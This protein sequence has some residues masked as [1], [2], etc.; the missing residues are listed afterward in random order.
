MLWHFIRRL[1][2]LEN[3]FIWKIP[4]WAQYSFSFINHSFALVQLS[5]DMLEFLMRF[6]LIWYC[7]VFLFILS[8]CNRGW[9]LKRNVLLILGVACILLRVYFFILNLVHLRIGFLLF[10]WLWLLRSFWF[11]P[12]IYP[13][14]CLPGNFL[15][16]DSLC[17]TLEEWLDRYFALFH[18]WRERW[19][20]SLS[21]NIGWYLIN[22][23]NWFR[24]VHRRKVY[25]WKVWGSHFVSGKDFY[26]F[27]A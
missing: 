14:L 24:S 4:T 23:S 22:L 7:I 6:L 20:I 27:K 9:L 26:L 17:F 10:E 1:T 16:L 15:C 12:A 25:I 19:I 13:W 21:R 11:V 3:T 18:T 2:I 8:I 5:L